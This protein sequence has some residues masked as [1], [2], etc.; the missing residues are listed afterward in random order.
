MTANELA[1]IILRGLKQ[2]VALIEQALKNE[3]DT[4]TIKQ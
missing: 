3:K 1:R 2:M 4:N